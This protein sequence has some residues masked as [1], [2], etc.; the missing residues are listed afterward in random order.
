MNRVALPSGAPIPALENGAKTEPEYEDVDGEEEDGEF[1]Y[2]DEPGDDFLG[3]ESGDNLFDPQDEPTGVITPP[4][5]AR[6]PAAAPAV[7]PTSAPVSSTSPSEVRASSQSASQPGKGLP[8]LNSV[9]PY[10][11][12]YRSAFTGT[13]H[14]GELYIN[15]PTDKLAFRLN[16]ML[17]NPKPDDDTQ[18]RI[19]QIRTILHY[20]DLERKARNGQ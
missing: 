15:F 3:P 17:K 16:A 9:G 2:L 5:T 13:T 1:E 19:D 12:T 4:E 6:M 11:L 14:E 8:D 7:P 18:L 10:R 20:R